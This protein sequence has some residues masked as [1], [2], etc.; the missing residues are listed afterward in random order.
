[1]SGIR[2]YTAA[3]LERLRT[4]QAPPGGG[5]SNAT[6]DQRREYRDADGNLVQVVLD[7]AGNQVRRRRKLVDGRWIDCQDV[8]IHLRSGV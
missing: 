2:P 4:V 5:W 7:Q 3:D 6:R 8:R 1:M